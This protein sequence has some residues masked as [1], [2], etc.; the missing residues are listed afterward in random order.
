MKDGE[1][2]HRPQTPHEKLRAATKVA[3]ARN[4]GRQVRE[5]GVESARGRV[6]AFCIGPL[7]GRPVY[8][9]GSTGLL[10]VFAAAPISVLSGGGSFGK[11]TIGGGGGGKDCGKVAAMARKILPKAG[12]ET[13]KGYT[14]KAITASALRFATLDR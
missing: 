8:L 6:A 12:K 10:N 11:G 7:C 9:P 1:R 3:E 13:L 4:S 5:R 14:E 2:R